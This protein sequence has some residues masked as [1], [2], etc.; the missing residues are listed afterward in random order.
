VVYRNDLPARHWIRVR[1]VG[2]PGNRAAAGAKIRLYAPG[3]Q[4][5]LWYE[6]MAVYDSQAAASYY[7]FAETDS[8]ASCRPWST[9]F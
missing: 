7:S 6:Q 9:A 1:P 5:L 8:A 3:T 2:L 4:Q